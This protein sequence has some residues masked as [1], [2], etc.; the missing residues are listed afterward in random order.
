LELHQLRCFLAIV[1]EGGFNRATTRL[2][3]TQPA[4][5]YQ[6]KQLEQE[7]GTSLFH[8]QPGGIS[9]TEAGRVLASHAREV[10]ESVRKAR[11]SVEKLADGV[12]GEVRIGT[13]N[14]VGIYF[15][16]QVLWNMK[17]KHPTV[18]PKVLYRHSN[19]IIEALLSNQI[20]LALVADP[21]PDRRLKQE[22]IVEERVSLVCGKTHPLYGKENAK[23]NDIKGLQFVALPAESPTGRLIHEHLAR[24]GVN[25]EPVVSSDN[26]ETVKKMVE[27]GMGAAFLPNMV[28]SQ[29]ITCNCSP[30]GRLARIEVGP[31]LHRRIVLVSWKNFDMSRATQAFVEELREHGLNWKDCVDPAEQCSDTF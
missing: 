3:I 20:D 29:D 15:L 10:L 11:R 5:S 13:V 18:N 28:T 9:P 8:R 22:I 2:H 4:L 27:I 21:K 7:L 31:T 16:P 14:S 17:Q 30:T 23:P 6:V 26:V 1:E 25:V 24:M 19:K 12:I